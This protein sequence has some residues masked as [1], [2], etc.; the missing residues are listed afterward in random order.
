MRFLKSREALLNSGLERI[1]YSG[2]QTGCWKLP[3]TSTNQDSRP[4]HPHAGHFL[5]D[6]RPPLHPSAV[7]EYGAGDSGIGGEAR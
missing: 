2:Q 6:S 1:S 5:N 7:D 4:P 3:P